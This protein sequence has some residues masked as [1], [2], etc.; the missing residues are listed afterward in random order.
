MAL[1]LEEGTGWSEEEASPVH[2]DTI[3]EES[4]SRPGPGEE[5]LIMSVDLGEGRS[6]RVVVHERDDASML[7]RDFCR[8]QGLPEELVKPLKEQIVA[9]VVKLGLREEKSRELQ[10]T[11]VRDKKKTSV[12]ADIRKS[13]ERKLTRPSSSTSFAPSQSSHPGERLYS[14]AHRLKET[15]RQ[16]TRELQKSLDSE[17]AKHLTFTPK[18]NEQSVELASKRRGRKG[19]V[20]SLLQRGRGGQESAERIRKEKLEREQSECTFKPAIDPISQLIVSSMHRSSSAERY[21][22]L[23]EDAERRKRL[24]SQVAEAYVH[25]ICTFQPTLV[26]KQ[27]PSAEPP[28]YLRLL[29]THK[30]RAAAPHCHPSLF[31]PITGRSPKHARKPNHTPIGEY[32]Y[33]LR[34]KPQAHPP[35]DN[36][37]PSLRND[38]SSKLL[39]RKR[40]QRYKEI[41]A[42]L[43]P[44]EKS[45]IRYDGIKQ[46]IVDSDLLLLLKP[47]LD[48]LQSLKVSLNF[49]EFEEA[50]DALVRTLDPGAKARLL[51]YSKKDQPPSPQA[52]HKPHITPYKCSE[53]LQRL[54]QVPQYERW[55]EG[56]RDAQTWRDTEKQRKD[57]LE[58]EECSFQPK[59][60]PYYCPADLPDPSTNELSAWV[61]D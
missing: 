20:D 35:R 19:S 5:I 1:R 28:L 60:R 34:P 56:R 22:Q 23:H 51:G 47:L 52:T 59:I 2:C 42:Q 8:R 38:A 26:A 7:A 6:G 15:T 9:N 45:E 29:P 46:E 37:A 48:E 55:K 49:S 57:A 54:L 16:R 31:H 32:L 53:R 43:L 4:S 12:P 21:V 3:P 44:D 58:L 39:Q 25:D 30:P 61:Q 18:L 40:L 27:I 13:S 36:P 17:A 10:R 33:S 41:F 24:Q 50:M 14:Q 11:P